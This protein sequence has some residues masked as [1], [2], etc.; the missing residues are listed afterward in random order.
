MRMQTQ[1]RDEDGHISTASLLRSIFGGGK[2]LSGVISLPRLYYQALV[3]GQQMNLVIVG[4][5]VGSVRS[6][7]EIVLVPEFILDLAIDLIDVLL[8]GDVEHA[9]TGLL[10]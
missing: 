9:P 6:V 1:L 7:A 5:L 4:I 10:R 8:F 3:F 2:R